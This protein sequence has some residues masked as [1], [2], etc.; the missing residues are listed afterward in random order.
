MGGGRTMVLDAF[1]VRPTPLTDRIQTTGTL[2]AEE[3][4]DLRNKASGQ[5][6][7]ILLQEGARVKK[8]DLL[9]KI[10]DLDLQAQRLKLEYKEKLAVEKEFRQR[11]MLSTGAVSQEEYD[12]TLN[13]LNTTRADRQLV[14]AQ[15]EDTEIR[16]P[17]DGTVGLRD[18]SEGAY[19]NPSTQIAS[20]QNITY[21]KVE[22]SIP[23]KYLARVKIGNAI[24]FKTTDSNTW[25]D[26][27]IYAAE[28]KI[29]VATR[30]LKLRARCPNPKGDILPGEFVD[31]EVELDK[32]PNAMVL[33]SYALIPGA[34]G[35]KTFV[36]DKGIAVYHDV[37]VGQ[38]D[39]LNVQITKGLQFGDTVLV[40]GLMQL[41]PMMPVKVQ[42][43]V[44]PENPGNVRS[45]AG[46]NASAPDKKGSDLNPVSGKSNRNRKKP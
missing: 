6:T 37:E 40:S 3:S 43:I 13:D 41:R 1:I 17:F 28:P 29:D 30:T 32:I 4:V 25:R 10:K 46:M 21:I 2:L 26:A 24:R 27:R 45:S 16:A 9:V 15:I 35:S 34:T 31:I 14:E 18:V 33:P 5:I 20:L 44:N 42:N 19:V 7:R 12:A 39:S 22:F 36:A 8:G 38:R 23:E 11:Q